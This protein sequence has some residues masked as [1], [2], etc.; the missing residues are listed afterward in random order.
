L[1]ENFSGAEKYLL[2]KNAYSIF[3]TVRYANGDLYFGNISNTLTK[4]G[5]GICYYH[6]GEFY[7]GNYTNDQR[8]SLNG[9]LTDPYKY[10]YKG[11]LVN[12]KMHGKG[13][14]IDA[15]IFERYDGSF[16]EG[17]RDGEG[18]IYFVNGTS[19]KVIYKNGVLQQ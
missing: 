13:E 2:G 11:E 5:F 12:N 19:K 8:N 1:P 9:I 10:V 15:R 18:T 6:T 17:E 16:K 14:Y 4:E 3:Y 7:A